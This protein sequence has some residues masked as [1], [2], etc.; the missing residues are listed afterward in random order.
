MHMQKSALGWQLC[1]Q[2]KDGCTSC[3]ERLADF[4]E[5][6][7]IKVAEHCL[8][9]G[10]DR[11]PAFAWWVDFAF[12]KRDC[13]IFAAKR[14][15]V[16]KTHKFRSRVPNNVHEVH[17]MDKEN[18]NTLRADAI[19]KE[20]KNVRSAFDIK[21]GNE[22]AP[23]GHQEIRRHGAFDV[24]MDGL[25]RKHRMVA[26]GHTTEAPKTLTHTSVVSRE[27]VRIVLTMAALNNLEV[28][29]ADTQ[30]AHLTASVPEKMW[31]RAGHIF[32]SDSGKIAVV[33]RTSCGLKSTGASF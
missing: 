22:K 23:I 21:K 24:K 14:R 27:S 26:G 1:I 2:W 15:V 12:K 19:A 20:M 10:I 11:K 25:A 28:K 8:A 6:K 9:R 7:P 33:A 32:G 18:S 3:W 5:F 13:I 16:K 30:N 17:A 29:A 4:K 31:T